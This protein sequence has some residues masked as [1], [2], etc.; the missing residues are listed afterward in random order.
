NFNNLQNL[1]I[2][3]A[4]Y[5][6]VFITRQD[7]VAKDV[8]DLADKLSKVI[9]DLKGKVI[10]KEYWGLRNLPYK[11]KKNTRGHYVL[12]NIDAEYDAISELKR[13]MKYNEDIIRNSIFRVTQHSK[14]RSQLMVSVSAKDYKAGE[15]S[16]A[17]PT[18]IDDIIDKIVINNN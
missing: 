15:V 5:E 2:N 1:N 7:L 18:E 16:K 14:N 13:V 12:L 6:A 8:D 17:E 9:G 3:M 4:L 11:I 10:S